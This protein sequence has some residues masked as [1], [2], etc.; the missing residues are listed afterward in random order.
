MA[1]EIRSAAP[2]GTLYARIMNHS[3]LWWNG[4]SFEAYTAI[5]YA[6]YVLTMTEQGNSGIY[7]A[8]FPSGITTGGSYEYF[9][10]RQAGGS[11]VEGDLV[12]STGT[13]DWSGIASISGSTGS[14][15]GSEWRDYVL[16]LGFIRTDKDTELYEATTDAIQEMRRRFMFDE[17]ETETTTTDTISVSG[18]FKLDVE[19]DSGLILG[20]IMQ[21]G[22]NAHELT[23]VSKSQ[24]N[25]LYPDINVTADRGYPEHY[26]LYAGQIYIGPIPDS[27]GYTYRMNYS[28]RAGTITSSTTGVPFTNVYRDVLADLVLSKLY[29]G[30]EEFDRASMYMNDFE[31][32]FLLATRKE[33]INSGDHTFTVKVLDC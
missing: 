19:S 29:K 27:T 33:I 5:N 12:V 16:R 25:A 10:H 26:C 23:R 7:V 17:A 2:S 20:V 30:L 9:V 32:G 1:R 14:M 4:S 21:D 31:K 22:A 6:N 11:P 15:T 28:R 3:G 24:F 8:D 13:V 18:D